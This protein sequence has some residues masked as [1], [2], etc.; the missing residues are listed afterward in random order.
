VILKPGIIHYTQCPV[1]GS[2][3]IKPTLTVRDHSV[4]GETFEVWECYSCKLRFT[5]DVP[6]AAHIGRYYQS[7]DYIS[8]SNTKKGVVNRL[9][10]LVRN[11][12]LGQKK[13]L[14]LTTTGLQKG[15]LLDVGAGAGTFAAYMQQA[16]WQVTALE[17]DADTRRNALEQY[18]VQ[19]QPSEQ[20]FE[21]VPQ[22]F[23]AITMW[24][25]LEHVHDLHGYLSQMKKLLKP[26]GVMFVAVPN[27]TSYDAKKYGS[28]WAAYDIPIHLYHFS[29][30]SMHRLMLA[31]GFKITGVRPMW[32]DSFYVSLLSEKY[33]SGKQHLAGGFVSGL[34]SNLNA[35]ANKRKCSSL[36]YIIE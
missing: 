33:K 17:P 19:L 21:L 14:I 4:T 24:H 36:I 3:T 29:P 35:L 12:T 28:Y 22:S 27:Y 7:A 34:I 20:L 5:Q 10:H 16:G 25:V 8:H 32:F 1:C 13:R 15:A 6:D 11:F 9:Y 2:D 31:H 30:A 18:Q 26:G 23:H